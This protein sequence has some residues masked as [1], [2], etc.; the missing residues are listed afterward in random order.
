M[1]FVTQWLLVH[2]RASARKAIR[3]NVTSWL[4]WLGPVMDCR[5]LSNSIFMGGENI[6]TYDLL[7]KKK[8]EYQENKAAYILSKDSYKP[9]YKSQKASWNPYATANIYGFGPGHICTTSFVPSKSVTT[10]A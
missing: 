7:G 4:C 10:V 8:T 5:I 2:Y 9:S 1:E 3:D 6:P